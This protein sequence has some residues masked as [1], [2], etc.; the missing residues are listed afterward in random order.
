ME[1]ASLQTWLNEAGLSHHYPA[2]ETA[3]MTVESLASLTMHNYNSV[4]VTNLAD[5]R[6]LFELI[7]QIKRDYPIT[8]KENVPPP[9]AMP[10]SQKQ[11]QDVSLLASCQVL[12]L[13]KEETDGL[14]GMDE[15]N[16]GRKQ[17]QQPQQQHQV[18]SNNPPPRRKSLGVGMQQGAGTATTAKK[19]GKRNV[20][21]RDRISVCVRKRPL[22]PNEVEK[23]DNDVLRVRGQTVYVQEP[24]QRVDCSQYTE[25]HA[26]TFDEVFEDHATNEDIF[27]RTAL[28]LMDTVF[29]GGRATCFAYGQ[30]GSGKTFTMLG[31]GSS[32]MGL[33]ALAAR[34]LFNRLEPNQ[35]ATCSYYEIYGSKL[36]DL[37]QNRQKLACREDSKGQVNICGL[38]EHRVDN[39]AAVVQIIEEGSAVRA[40]GAT[41]A[42]LIGRY[43]SAKA[44]Y[45]PETDSEQV[46]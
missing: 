20:P 41:G 10:K 26:F 1:V 45:L 9:A 18:H 42:E 37:L 27:T 11:E 14:F 15:L 8:Q 46:Q 22:N 3:G 19:T 21:L 13:D 36:F 29:E 38:T 2:F 24:K 23:G 39:V 35:F 5:R 25:E 43:P 31:K 6:K 7:Q 30:T 16:G 4:G 33:Y 28:P 17:Q 12:P 40:Q 32:G 44:K 34:D